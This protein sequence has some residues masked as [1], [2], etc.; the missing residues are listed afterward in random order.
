MP[1]TAESPVCERPRLLVMAQLPPPVHGAA[2]M[3]AWAARSPLLNSRYHVAL[4]PLRFAS[5]IGDISRFRLSKLAMLAATLVHMLILFAT[6]RPRLFYLTLSPT[7]NGF[8]RDVLFVAVARLFGVARVYHLHGKGIAGARASASW[9]DRLYRWVFAGAK[10]IV[11][12]PLVRADVTGLVH[13]TDIAVVNN[14]IPDPAAGDL[15]APDRTEG[16]TRILFLS[17][18]IPDKGFAVLLE[19]MSLL[20][21]RGIEAQADF[22][23]AWPT[24]EAEAAFAS[25]VRGRGLSDRVRHHGPQYGDAKAALFRRCDVFAFPTMSDCFP[26][27]LLEAMAFGVPVVTTDEGGIPDIVADGVSGFI[28]PCRDPRA[29]ADRLERLLDDRA[30]RQA[31]G[32]AGRRLYLERFQLRHF[33]NALCAALDQFSFMK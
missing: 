16:P 17:N 12:S 3:N 1:E 24:P 14:G 8:L 10:V 15:A 33:E 9:L 26:T 7:G 21:A 18:M 29:L 30:L 5:G 22:A 28:V 27:V 11:L 13:E 23:G 19:A 31:M 4:L 20:K 6:F 32:A 2:L 25:A